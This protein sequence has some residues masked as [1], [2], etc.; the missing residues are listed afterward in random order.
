MKDWFKIMEDCYWL[1]PDERGEDE[2]RFIKKELKLNPRQRLL[3]APCGAGRVSVH[4]ARLGAEVT[5]ID[6]RATFIR[7][8][9]RRFKKEG[10]KGSFRVMDLRKLEMESSFDAIM[11][12]SGS[13]GY[14]SEDENS[15]LIGAFERALRPKGQ[16]L[17]EMPNRG[18]L[19][20]NKKSKMEVGEVTIRNKW[21]AKTQRVTSKRTQPGFDPKLGISSMRLYTESQM[22]LLFE[23][24]GLTVEKVVRSAHFE[25]T[26][27]FPRMVIIGR[28][29]GR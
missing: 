12:W 16:L 26:G 18:Y 27:K 25:A 28:K 14:F 23:K 4:L 29:N 8:A 6:I 15:A 11:N 17:V 5:G 19:L 3:D 22:R 24:H 10:Q 20:R 21:D 9:R 1:N 7:R 13:F 2:A